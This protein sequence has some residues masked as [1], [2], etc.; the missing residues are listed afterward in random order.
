M[1]G[2]LQ[3]VLLSALLLCGLNLK[4]Q[5]SAPDVRVERGDNYEF[6]KVLD[7]NNWPYDISNNKENML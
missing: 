5:M 7:D 6:V 2:F 4:A 3:S 1:K